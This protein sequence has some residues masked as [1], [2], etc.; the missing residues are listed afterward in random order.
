M[1][2]DRDDAPK[3]SQFVFGNIEST[4]DVDYSRAQ[5]LIADALELDSHF[6]I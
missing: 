1:P 2:E 6:V 5:V 3:A 4:E